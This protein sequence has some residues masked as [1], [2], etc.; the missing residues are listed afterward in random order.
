[1][2]NLT[3]EDRGKEVVV[4]NERVG[5][6]TDVGGDTVFV[7]PDFDA[8]PEEIR[9]RFDWVRTDD[10]YTLPNDAVADVRNDRVYLRDELL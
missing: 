6:V 7:D 2:P 10:R 8:A 9:Q 4:V 5:V 1:M 3:D